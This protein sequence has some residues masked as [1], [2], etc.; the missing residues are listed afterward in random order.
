MCFR[1]K[2][3]VLQNYALKITGLVEKKGVGI[4]NLI[5]YNLK[6]KK[7]KFV[8]KHLQPYGKVSTT[9]E[10]FLGTV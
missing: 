10:L 6:F 9:Q 7:K 8:L 4:D 1:L 3:N 2:P 5:L